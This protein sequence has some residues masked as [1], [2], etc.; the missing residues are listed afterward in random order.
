MVCRNVGIFCLL[1]LTGAQ[2]TVLMMVVVWCIKILNWNSAMKVTFSDMHIVLNCWKIAFFDLQFFYVFWMFCILLL[3]LCEIL[4]SPNFEEEP[5]H[6]PLGV[7]VRR[8]RKVYRHG[9]KVAVDGLTMN[10]YE[11]QITSFLGHNGAGKTTTMWVNFLFFLLWI[12]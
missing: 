5:K 3:V 6:L 10:F 7:A 2:S 12:V 11:G 4:V 9:N 8:L 1:N